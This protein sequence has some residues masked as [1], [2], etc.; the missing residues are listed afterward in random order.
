[1]QRIVEKVKVI[2]DITSHT[3]LLAI[4]AS[5]EASRA[6]DHG[7]GFAVV[8]AEIRKLSEL[9]HRAS[10]EIN[11]LS[12]VSLAATTQTVE[13]V[14]SISP[15]IH[16]N[17]IMVSRIS[18]ACSKQLHFTGTISN[19]VQQLT[20]ISQNNTVSADKLTVYANVLFNDVERLNKLVDFFRLD[21]DIDLRRD[22]ILAAIE[23]CKTEILALKTKLIATSPEG[24]AQTHAI[25]DKIDE[26]LQDDSQ[27]AKN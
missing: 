24:D 9:C 21:R 3:D 12:E 13:L 20:E 25:E 17:A 1:M 14:D 16:D 19:S 26:V 22:D 23:V 18:E 6:G 15:K 7:T 11:R 2:N 10:T 27:P 5:V 8:A 4:N